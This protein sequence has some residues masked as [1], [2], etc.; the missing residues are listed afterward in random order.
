MAREPIY[1]PQPVRIIGMPTR[2]SSAPS[3]RPYI[4]LNVHHC[5]LCHKDFD[6]HHTTS[7]SCKVAHEWDAEN[8]VQDLVAP[9]GTTKLVF[10]S[11]CTCAA[12]H[13]T[14]SVTGDDDCE[15]DDEHEFVRGGEYCYVGP[16]ITD[17]SVAARRYNGLSLVGCKEAGCASGHGPVNLRF[18]REAAYGGPPGLD[19]DQIFL[20]A[21][22]D[23]TYSRRESL[24]E[25]QRVHYERA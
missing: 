17:P 9:P 1:K 3:P 8:Y 5:Q 23:R 14:L 20:G 13:T 12:I 6:P 22:Y 19:Q 2:S 16:H 15:F 21:P 7:T 4:P 24:E 18:Y 25:I 10:F 11:R